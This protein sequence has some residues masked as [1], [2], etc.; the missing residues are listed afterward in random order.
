[1]EHDSSGERGDPTASLGGIAA[2]TALG[3]QAFRQVVE[4]A[5]TAI[6]LVD[7]AGRIALLNAQAERLFAFTR[8]ELV[9]QPVERLVPERFGRHAAFREQFLAD[10]R[11]RPMGHTRELYARRRDGSEFPVDIGLSPVDLGEGPMVLA[12]V[13]DITDRH[14]LEE[15]FRRV[16][17]YAPSAM[18]MIDPIGSIVLVNAQTEAMFGYPREA[19]IGR[20]IEI[21]VPERFRGHHE[22]YRNGFFADRRPRPMGSGRELFACRAD[23][24]EFPVEIGLNPI[25]TEDGPMVLASVVDITERRR[26]Q[27]AMERA[28]KEKTAL[29]NEVH[30]RVKNNL[31]VISSLLNLQAAHAEDPR[32]QAILGESQSRVKAMALTHQLLYERRDFSQVDL[33]EYLDRLV[34]S[35]RAT[36]RAG[37]NGVSLRLQVPAEPVHL[38]LDRAIPCGLLVNEL[39]TNSFKH[40]FPG[41][42]RGEIR[43]GLRRVDDRGVQLEVGDDGVGLPEDFRLEEVKSLGLQLVPLFA[44]QLRA[45]LSIDGGQG[46]RI[47]VHFSS[48]AEPGS[49]P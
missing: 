11:P 32:L 48:P 42:R 10:A 9:G 13:V 41:D 36:H 35:L 27:Q 3:A 19:L 16:V 18:V 30:H 8:D 1:M 29:L 28:L 47:A 44:D 43:V 31:Q 6:V 15:R 22:A 12:A 34:Q 45:R 17:E 25:D 33:G 26:S 7:G 2:R 20:F 14:R 46:T 21:L 24:S 5:P 4:H 49:A 23:G 39:V 38:D 40:A 37:L